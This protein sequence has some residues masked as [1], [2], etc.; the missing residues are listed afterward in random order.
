MPDAEVEPWEAI[1]ARLE[2]D[3]PEHWADPLGDSLPT[4]MATTD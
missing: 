2:N 1:A 4:W 3:F